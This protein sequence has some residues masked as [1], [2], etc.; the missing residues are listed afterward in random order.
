MIVTSRL[1]SGQLTNPSQ[2]PADQS[3]FETQ[4]MCRKGQWSQTFHIK[5]IVI[6]IV[7][8]SFTTVVVII[9]GGKVKVSTGCMLMFFSQCVDSLWGS[10]GYVLCPSGWWLQ[11]QVVLC[12]DSH[13]S[14]G[15]WGLGLGL[16]ISG[17]GWVG[18]VLWW[19]LS[20][21]CRLVN[22][23]LGQ[24]GHR[25]QRV[26]LVFLIHLEG[27]GLGESTESNIT[28]KQWKKWS[29]KT[30]LF[31]WVLFKNK[32]MCSSLT[33]FMGFSSVHTRVSVIVILLGR[34]QYANK[35]VV[36]LY[37]WKYQFHL[38]TRTL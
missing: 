32:Q 13:L 17:G 34:L 37:S 22:G 10:S 38:S 6:V 8:M 23:L 26:S 27:L 31:L 24:W 20:I 36:L 14:V 16:S 18:P 12:H 5:G 30:D 33:R 21:D 35:V 3:L 9:P 4:C 25:H 15:H 7:V 11:E 1:K 28:C 2:C 19:R 29:L